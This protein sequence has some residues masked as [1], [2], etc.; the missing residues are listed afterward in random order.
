VSSLAAPLVRRVASS[1]THPLHSARAARRVRT[2]LCPAK[3]AAPTALQA[4]TALC[5]AA[6]NVW[7]VRLERT[8][9]YEALPGK[10]RAFVALSHATS[11]MLEFYDATLFCR[12]LECPKTQFQNSP[13]QS[14][15]LQC[16]VGE[17]YSHTAGSCGKVCASVLLERSVYFGLTLGVSYVKS[18]AL[19]KCETGA[20]CTPDIIA[21]NGNYF[22]Y[23]NEDG[24]RLLSTP[25]QPGFCRPCNASELTISNTTKV[26]TCCAR[27]H[28]SSTENPLCGACLDGYSLW[29]GMLYLFPSFSVLRS[30]LSF[31]V[32]FCRRMCCV[33]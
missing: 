12:C 1:P 17:F 27:N 16:S 30:A 23:L 18:I 28:V 22:L 4:D 2:L 20:D 24:S 26:F 21:P 32:D 10:H 19:V 6:P 15:C 13:G 8:R 11:F 9:P 33:H 29:G 7:P 25:C 14:S 31:F 5:R 3:W